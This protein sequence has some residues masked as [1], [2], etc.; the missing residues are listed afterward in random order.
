MSRQKIWIRYETD[1]LLQD[2]FKVVVWHHLAPTFHLPSGSCLYCTFDASHRTHK[3]STGLFIDQKS[4]KT[5]AMWTL[6]PFRTIHFLRICRTIEWQ[7][8]AKTCKNPVKHIQT[9]M[10]I[11]GYVPYIPHSCLQDFQI[12][13]I[14]MDYWACFGGDFSWRAC[15]RRVARV[16]RL[17]IGCHSAIGPSRK[18]W[19][20]GKVTLCEWWC[21]LFFIFFGVLQTSNPNNEF[22]TK[23]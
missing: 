3:S 15:N 22:P 2:V 12:L 7:N 20:D 10:N 8:L 6:H 5:P 19:P 14:N 21:F 23:Q 11:M 4:Q 9:T 18:D 13:S 16:P 17:C 1:V